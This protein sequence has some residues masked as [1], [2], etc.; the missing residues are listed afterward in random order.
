MIAVHFLGFPTGPSHAPV[1][2]S[3]VVGAAPGA[4]VP[5]VD[6]PPRPFQ[7]RQTKNVDEG[8]LA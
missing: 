1:A 8:A 4:R 3:L 7:P 5:P 2:A 6:N